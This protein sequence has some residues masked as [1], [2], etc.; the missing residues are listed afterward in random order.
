MKFSLKKISSILFILVAIGFFSFSAYRRAK[1]RKI[2][3]E[4]LASE[5][6]QGRMKEFKAEPRTTGHIVF[7]GNSLTEMFD[8]SALDDSTIINRG[9]TGDFS[10]G[11]LQRIDEV[12]SL[13]PSKLFLEVG[14][15]D[16]VEH[17]SV[18]EIC[19][20]YKGIVE[21][22]R[23]KS[24]ETKIYFQSVLPVRMI[25][26]F[27]TSSAD[28]NETVREMN[29]ALQQVA[30]EQHVTF[31]NLYDHY[32]LDGEINPRLTWDGVHLADEGYL[33]WKGLLQPYLG[34]K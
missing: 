18:K 25:S 16:L 14:I 2:I 9:I 6:W 32:V 30:D 4:T 12:I 10:E 8:L 11:T 27:L 19:R 34:K 23:S 21:Q 24:P 29:A 7:M 22:V 17:V 31:I 1:T 28:V 26:S 33:I 3:R 13:H 5:H 20:N 15:N